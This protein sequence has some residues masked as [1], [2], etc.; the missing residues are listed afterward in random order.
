MVH[1]RMHMDQ[2]TRDNLEK[3]GGTKAATKAIRASFGASFESFINNNEKFFCDGSLEP[4]PWWREWRKEEPSP[5]PLTL[6]E[7]VA[8]DRLREVGLYFKE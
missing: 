7:I 3:G 4:Y 1:N 5:D 6:A 2:E 8:A